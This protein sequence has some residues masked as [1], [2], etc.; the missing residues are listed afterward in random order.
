MNLSNIKL[1]AIFLVF[2][3]ELFAVYAET[4]AVKFSLWSGGFWKMF[5]IMVLGGFLLVAG[6]V[7]GYRAYQNLWIITVISITTLLIA[8]PLVILVFFK[9]IP[10]VGAIIGF[11][12]GIIG[13]FCSIFF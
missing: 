10:T 13:L 12:L 11:I 8:E 3:G 5:L 2:L 7:L 9:Q 4:F 1:L 6:Y